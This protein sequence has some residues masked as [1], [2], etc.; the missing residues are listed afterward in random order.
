MHG[1]ASISIRFDPAVAIPRTAFRSTARADKA[2]DFSKRGSGNAFNFS[3]HSCR[4]RAAYD[5]CARQTTASGDRVSTGLPPIPD[6]AE[7]AGSGFSVS[8][9]V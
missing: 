8:R 1:F 5:A 2:G 6:R 9:P 7:F 4:L 3:E